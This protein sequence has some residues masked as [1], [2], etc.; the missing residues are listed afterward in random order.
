MTSK[1]QFDQSL[2]EMVS[3]NLT[4]HEVLSLD[5]DG[6][7]HAAVAF[8]LVNAS[9]AANIANI[10]YHAEQRSEAAYILT[11]RTA[12]LSSHAGQRAYPGGR[13]DYGETAQQ[14]GLAGTARGGRIDARQQQRSRAPGRLPDPFRIRDY[15]VRD[16][17]W[18]GRRTGGES[19]RGRTNPPNPVKTN[20]CARRHRYSI[21]SRKAGTRCCACRWARTG[22]RHPAQRL[23]T[24]FREVA[25]FGRSTRVSH[26]EQPVFRVEMTNL[27][28]SLRKQ[29]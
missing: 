16:L 4:R 2:R 15:A 13:V 3:R 25:L 10:P 14:G 19:C 7:K 21:R 27:K 9:E 5:R 6:R 18:K 22:S 11:T 24:S 20:C 28:S 29:E 26:Y 23:P 8:T 1:Y 17:G 12:S